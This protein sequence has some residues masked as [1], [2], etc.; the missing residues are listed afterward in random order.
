MIMILNDRPYSKNVFKTFM[1]CAL[2]LSICTVVPSGH[3]AVDTAK[4]V[5]DLIQRF[6]EAQYKM[7][8]PTLQALTAE[9]Y[10]EV[11]PLGEV[12]TREKMLTFYVKKDEKQVLPTMTV[13]DSTTRLLG[14]TAVVIAK[15]SYTSVIE[16]QSRTF[17]LRST[18]VAEKI[19]GV[20]KLVSAHYT[21][22]RPPKNPD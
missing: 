16:G 5:N 9:N 8:V 4:P 2:T 10:I 14:N 6:T 20:W 19:S 15:V 7:D 11:S 13:E 1:Q 18:F 17:S 12:D 21:A 3:S 22:I